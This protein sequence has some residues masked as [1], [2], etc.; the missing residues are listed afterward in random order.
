MTQVTYADGC[1]E[2]NLYDDLNRLVEETDALGNP[3][4][5]HYRATKRNIFL[6]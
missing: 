5:Y 6:Y 4:R 2:L 1:S 3:T